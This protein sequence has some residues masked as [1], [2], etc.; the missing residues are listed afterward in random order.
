MGVIQPFFYWWSF[1]LEG[2]ISDEKCQVI[3]LGFQIQIFNN[4]SINNHHISIFR[5]SS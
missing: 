3:F 2:E 4:N 1:L 5:Q